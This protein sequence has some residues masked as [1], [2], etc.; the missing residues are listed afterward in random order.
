MD[1]TDPSV[2]TGMNTGVSTGPWAVCIT[3]ARARVFVDSATI[4]NLNFSSSIPV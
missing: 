3:P 2:P 1:F 4:S